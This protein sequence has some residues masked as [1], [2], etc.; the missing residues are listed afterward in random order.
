MKR[1]IRLFVS[2]S[3]DLV[4]E[5]EIV[6]QVIAE[7]PLSIGWRI[8]HTPLPGQPAGT[9]VADPGGSD[10]YV[11]LLG[12]DFSAPMGAEIREGLASGRSLQAFRKARSQSPSAQDA[13][14]RMKANW[15][16]FTQPEELRRLLSADL[17]QVLLRRATQFGLELQEL[18]KLSELARPDGESRQ[19][20]REATTRARPE[21][22][23][24]RG[25]V[26][27]GREIWQDEHAED[28]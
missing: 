10:L 18:E 26:I 13:F 4:V 14:R 27:L 16:V 22:D 9:G 24:E 2:S 25:G 19:D 8:G 28:R 3:P 6:G 21:G 17:V 23:V 20:E 1:A 15:R 12:A 11:V 5:R 7:L